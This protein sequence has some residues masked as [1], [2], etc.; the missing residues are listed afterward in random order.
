MTIRFVLSHWVIETPQEAS[1]LYTIF[2]NGL[3]AHWCNQQQV[4]VDR[5]RE[6]L[7]KFRVE[8]WPESFGKFVKG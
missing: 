1:V 6:Q 7:T 2:N 4:N 5:I 8:D 3:V